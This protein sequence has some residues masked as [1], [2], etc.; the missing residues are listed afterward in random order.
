MSSYWN[1]IPSFSEDIPLQY[2]IKYYILKTVHSKT[3][4]NKDGQIISFLK[5]LM[6]DIRNLKAIMEKNESTQKYEQLNK[7]IF[8]NV[9]QLDDKY[10][11]NNFNRDLIEQ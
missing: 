7:A 5:A 3:A 4:G 2:V 9:Q 1:I 8:L 6:N 11:N 10:Q